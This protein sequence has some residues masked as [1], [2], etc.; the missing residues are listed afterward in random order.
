MRSDSQ[1]ALNLSPEPQWEPGWELEL[2]EL[3]DELE[4]P[5]PLLLLVDLGTSLSTR[6][7]SSRGSATL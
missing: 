1:R 6:S 2:L 4:P 7:Q 5:L 3:L